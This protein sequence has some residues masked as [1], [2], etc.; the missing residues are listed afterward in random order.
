VEGKSKSQQKCRS[1]FFYFLCVC[2]VLAGCQKVGNNDI[3]KV[4]LSVIE[5]AGKDHTPR[6]AVLI[7][8]AAMISPTETFKYY[9]NLVDYI[10]EKLGMPVKLVQKKTYKEMNEL[11]EAK[12]VDFALVCSGP[13]T[14]GRKK[15]GME[16]LAAPLVHGEPTYYAYIIVHKD[17]PVERFEQ[18]EGRTFGFTDPHSNTG[19]IVPTYMLKKLGKD[20]GTFFK[21][22]IF[23]GSHDHSI[24]AVAE[25][26][27]DAAS[28][29]SLIY[30]YMKTIDPTV[31][32]QTKILVKSPPFG[33]P[34]VVC[35]PGIEAGLKN[36]VKDILLHMHEEEKGKAILQGILID[37]FIVAGDSLYDSIREMQDVIDGKKE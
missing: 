24:H 13:Y 30:D 7:G 18:L 37:R 23:T 35:N 2:S 5:P 14:E 22:I 29:D 12:K 28:V 16:L 19:Y 4:D 27:V 1:W 25:R 36:K 11:I 21:K 34:P 10:G 32:A 20:S 9:I 17:D 26:L 31:V 3:K 33:M 6:E 15:F 8:V